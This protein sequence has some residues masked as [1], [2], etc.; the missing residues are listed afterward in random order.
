MPAISIVIPVR[1]G[2]SPETTLRSLSRQSFQDFEVI[3]SR[4]EENRGAPWARNQGAQ[5]AQGE[6]I[7]FSDDDIDWLPHALEEMQASLIGNAWASYAY[8]GYRC[9][10]IVHSNR[11]FEARALQQMNFISTMA[12]VRRGDHPGWDESLER[13][14]DWDVYLTMLEQGKI[15]VWCGGIC[16]STEKRKGITYGGKVGWKEAECVVK[17]KHAL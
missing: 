5:L 9:D 6:Y 2:G 10:G 4:D 13:L 1:R 14:Q 12:L 16:F 15:G 17:K 8:G 3:L 7:L 11:P